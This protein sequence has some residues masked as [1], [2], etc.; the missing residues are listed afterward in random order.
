MTRLLWTQRQDIGPAA[1]LNFDMVYD[2]ARGRG[3]LFGGWDLGALFDDTWEW[4][5][6]AWTQA[7]DMGPSPRRGHA[8]A[9]DSMRER[10]VLFGGRVASDVACDTWE[11]DGDSWTQVADTGPSS[12]RDHAMTFDT[13]R[14]RVLLFGGH[15]YDDSSQ[16]QG[17]TWAW[18]GKER[19]SRSRI[20]GRVPDSITSLPTTVS[21]TAPCYSAA[22]R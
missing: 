13:R 22:S 2:A 6:E 3:V 5:G 7:A 10:V 16:P 9:Y 15:G 18:D 12:R 19:Y 8:L 11:W 4:D 20:P 17:D 21:V 1:R 14:G